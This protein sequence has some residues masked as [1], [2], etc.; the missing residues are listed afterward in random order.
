M[1]RNTGDHCVTGP[2][3][4]CL[5]ST[6]RA[7]AA[8][9]PSSP[10]TAR[11]ASSSA[12][13]RGRPSPRTRS[14]T[15]PAISCSGRTRSAPACAA[16]AG[17]DGY[18]AV[19]SLCAM[20]IPPAA[21]SAATPAAPS[22][23]LPLST[24]ATAPGPTESASDVSSASCGRLCDGASSVTESVRSGRTSICDRAGQ[25]ATR[26]PSSAAPSCAHTTVRPVRRSRIFGSTL[27]CP[28]R[29]CC[30]RIGTVSSGSSARSTAVKA[31]SP[32]ADATS[33]TTSTAWRSGNIG[34][35]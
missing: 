16:A 17:I 25:T 19:S 14:V 10:K 9:L 3:G 15:T 32:P 21:R 4:V 7:N 22:L 2:T 24:T 11:S 1:L 8:T 31:S 28:P 33:P 13:G 5:Q 29:C 23:P 20:T 27:A 6:S 26:P 12:P 18:S 34:S 35:A 30:N